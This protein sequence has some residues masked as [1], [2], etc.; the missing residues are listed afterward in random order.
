MSSSAKNIEKKAK[1]IANHYIYGR[2]K[3]LMLDTAEQV[4]YL[5]P[6]DKV[7]FLRQ[8]RIGDLLVSTPVFR[9][10]SDEFPEVETDILLSYRNIGAS[11]GVK[12]YCDEI[13]V[14]NKGLAEIKKLISKIRSKKY[15]LIIDLFDNAST[16]SSAIIKFGKPEYSLGF[17]KE[18]RRSYDFTVPIPDKAGNH[19][20]KRISRLL[21]PFGIDMQERYLSPVY[22]FDMHLYKNVYP[23]MKANHGK[24][25]FAIN[26]SGSNRAKYWGTENYIKF[27][28]RILKLFSNL[29]PICFATKDYSEELEEIANKT[30]VRTAPFTS[31]LDEYAAMLSCCDLIL[32]PDTAAVHFASAFKIPCIAMYD[33]SG[34]EIAG[35]PWTPVNIPHRTIEIKDK[36][37]NIKVIDVLVN[38][39]SL[40]EECL[41]GCK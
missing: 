7:L 37:E 19:I 27:I 30:G 11:A 39:S 10:F 20:S 31:S 4:I 16:T 38:L 36:I 2:K 28:N 14:Y 12:D 33:I 9:R 34:L 18:N 26:L 22:P 17:D 1:R 3:P 15:K 32:T 24:Q 29:E 21:L 8:D 13:L 25:L 6:G 5:N 41:S 40:V 23:K 35:M